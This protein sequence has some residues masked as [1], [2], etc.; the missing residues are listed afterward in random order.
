WA[1]LHSSVAAQPSPLTALLART[2]AW[3][4]RTMRSLFPPIS[5]GRLRFRGGLFALPIYILL[6]LIYPLSLQQAEWVRTADHFTWLAVLGVITGVL[7]GNTRM[8]TTRAI[9]LGGVLGAIAIVIAT[10][11]ATEGNA[12]LREKLV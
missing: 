10:S 8:S 12:I 3:T 2:R 9:V 4:A 6:V 11:M 5:R 1:P 7:V